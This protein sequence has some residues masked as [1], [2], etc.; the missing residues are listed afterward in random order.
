MN[1]NYV[2]FI[3]LSNT[4]SPVREQRGSKPKIVREYMTSVAGAEQQNYLRLF[5]HCIITV[6]VHQMVIDL[7]H[8]TSG[9]PQEMKIC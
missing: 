1:L 2:Y 6:S 9:V 5:M 7:Y 8:I 4:F 3:C